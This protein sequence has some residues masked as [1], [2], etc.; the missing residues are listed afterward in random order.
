VP[1]V[2]GVALVSRLADRNNQL[3]F[4]TLT[5][6]VKPTEQGIDQV[7]LP[8]PLLSSERNHNWEASAF[9]MLLMYLQSTELFSPIRG[10]N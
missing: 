3:W 4:D 6:R 1:C 9:Y 7:T 10:D 5:T 8:W 2:Y